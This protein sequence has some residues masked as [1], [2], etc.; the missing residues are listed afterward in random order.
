VPQLSCGW[1]WQWCCIGLLVHHTW[2]STLREVFHVLLFTI[3][4]VPCHYWRWLM[5]H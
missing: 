1:C 3:L 4:R 5:L 2:I